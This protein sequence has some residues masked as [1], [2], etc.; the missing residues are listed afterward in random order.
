MCLQCKT[1]GLCITLQSYFVFLQ[2]AMVVAFL[3]H[4]T[5]YYLMLR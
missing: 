5:F 4:Y 1:N 2:N 3:Q